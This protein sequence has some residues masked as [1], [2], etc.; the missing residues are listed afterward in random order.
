MRKLKLQVQL[1]LDGFM[2]GPNGEMD[3]MEWNWDEEI[4]QHVANITEPIE[5]IILG[6]KLAEGFIPHWARVAS[7]PDD[8]EFTA[9][10]KF[11]DTPKI[12]FTKN[13]KKAEWKNTVL[14]KRGLVEEINELKAQEGGDIIAYG[15][16]QFVSALIRAGLIDK[17]HLFTNPTAIGTGLPLFSELD[18]KL[19]LKLCDSKTFSC[20]IVANTYE[21]KD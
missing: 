1:T 19:Q 4:K 6:R 9:G 16:V 3:W 10:K 15:G 17:Y 7:N 2:A 8:P 5:C 13:L 11:T 20:G 18:K 21:P 12:V 14:A